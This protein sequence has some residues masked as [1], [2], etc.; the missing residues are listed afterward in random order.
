MI[1]NICDRSCWPLLSLRLC[2]L[3]LLSQT[4][5][6]GTWSYR[7]IRGNVVE[8]PTRRFPRMACSGLWPQVALKVTDGRFSLRAAVPVTDSHGRWTR[9]AGLGPAGAGA[10]TPMGYW[11]LQRASPGT[12]SPAR[13]AS[14]THTCVETRQGPTVEIKAP[15]LSFTLKCV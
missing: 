11:R 15:V 4:A 7:P 9:L 2:G 12:C 10:V 5:T 8:G 13:S 6:S 14:N 3:T 1:I